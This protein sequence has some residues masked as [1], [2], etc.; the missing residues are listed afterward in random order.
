MTEIRLI[1]LI[2]PEV[3]IGDDIVS[4]I[5]DSIRERN[6]ELEDRD[7]IAI[8]S[9]ILSK[10][11]GLLYK[12]VDIKPSRE[13]L[14]IAK[15]TG[16]DPRVAEIIIRESDEIIAA[17]P[18][19]KLVEDNVIDPELLSRDRHRLLQAINFYP[20]VLITRRDCSL[21]SDAGIDTSNH[22]PGVYSYP[23]RDLDTIAR[24][25]HELI[26]SRTGVRVGVVVCDTELFP[27]GSL[28]IARGSYGVPV[29][30]RRFGEPD[31]YGKPKF[32][33]VDAI[34]TSVCVAASLLM[35][36]HAEG[37]PVVLIKGLEYEWDTNGVSLLTSSLDL[38]RALIETIKHTVKVLGL[39][40]FTRLVLR[41]NKARCT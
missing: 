16:L 19:K 12:L 28:D 7:I 39:R 27:F 1:G 11:R 18:F 33:G 40:V 14:R 32:G 29:T 13:A 31:M 8:T 36:Q 4:L 9:K 22:P 34:A 10:S 41:Q 26:Y 24:E 20:T 35:G 25:L 21:W 3:E 6:I 15:K 37:I 30:A 38:S 5:L 2:L 23:P 17:I